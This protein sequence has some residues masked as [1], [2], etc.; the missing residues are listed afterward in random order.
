M[1]NSFKKII[2][3]A[4]KVSLSFDE[5]ESMRTNL[6]SYMGEVPLSANAVWSEPPRRSVLSFLQSYAGTSVLMPALLL[7]VLIGGGTLT[8]ASQGALPGD[9]MYSM[10]KLSEKIDLFFAFTPAAEA[11]INA[12]QAV[13]RLEEAEVLSSEGRFTGV[14]KVSIE[15]SFSEAS[16]AALQRIGQLESENKST[17]LKVLTEFRG[18]L[19][20]HKDILQSMVANADNAALSSLPHEVQSVIAILNASTTGVIAVGEE[21]DN[22]ASEAKATARQQITDVEKY[23]AAN[24]TGDVKVKALN[25][26]ITAR[27]SYENGTQALDAESYKD[28]VVLFRDA[29]GKA[30]QAKAIAQSYN[31]MKRVIGKTA[32]KKPSDEPTATMMMATSIA[33]TSTASTTTVTAST[34][35]TTTASTTPAATSTNATS[36]PTGSSGSGGGVQVNFN[37]GGTIVPSITVGPLGL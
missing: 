27:A 19:F 12:M 35:A 20:A 37:G 9:A 8:L 26:L 36:S 2:K 25:A 7:F 23:V 4:K 22:S 29:S 18:N 5:R 3:N 33:A 32:A 24:M 6:L 17:G 30:I 34:T 14:A 13:R 11:R 21:N 28:A 16:G 15:A 31:S 1:K 10:K